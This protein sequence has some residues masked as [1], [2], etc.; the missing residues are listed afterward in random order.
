MDIGQV[1]N[2]FRSR[3]HPQVLKNGASTTW[4]FWNSKE[5]KHHGRE[6]HFFDWN[7]FDSGFSV[8]K[9]ELCRAFYGTNLIVIRLQTMERVNYQQHEPSFSHDLQL[10]WRLPTC[11]CY[12]T[13][14]HGHMFYDQISSQNLVV[15][16]KCLQTDPRDLHPE[17][18]HLFFQIH[19]KFGLRS[20]CSTITMY[21]SQFE[22]V[23]RKCFEI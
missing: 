18:I 22:T 7:P 20:T 8:L 9:K 11:M 17:L 4:C 19:V 5:K 15:D 10:C 2:L 14:F 23:W 1:T 3:H 21:Y 16:T 12:Q 13:F 6:R